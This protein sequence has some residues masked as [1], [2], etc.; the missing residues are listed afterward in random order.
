ME[1]QIKISP[2]H[3]KKV[4][5]SIFNLLFFDDSKPPLFQ[6]IDGVGVEMAPFCD[7]FKIIVDKG[8]TKYAM[9]HFLDQFQQKMPQDIRHQAF[10]MM[11]SRPSYPI[12]VG[13]FLKFNIQNGEMDQENYKIVQSMMVHRPDHP[14]VKSFIGELLL[15]EDGYQ[16]NKKSYIEKP[17]YD[18]IIKK[19]IKKYND[20]LVIF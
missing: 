9:E 16:V 12:E 17:W 20:N 7:N 13:F 15:I 5:S 1:N 6:T 3:Q 2:Y 8:N 19:Q 11:F 10:L 4:I 14:L 18:S